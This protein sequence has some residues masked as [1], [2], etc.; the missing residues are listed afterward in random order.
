VSPGAASE[1]TEALRAWIGTA[2]ADAEFMAALEGLDLRLALRSSDDEVLVLLAPNGG[3]AEAGDRRDISITAPEYGW[4]EIL[5]VSPGPGW[6]AFTALAKA[7]PEAEVA[8]DPAAIARALHALERLFELARPDI[9]E[10][11]P[12]G[13]RNYAAIIGRYADVVGP[14]QRP[15]RI[16]YETAGEGMPL[17]MLHTAGA[18]SRQW[19]AQLADTGLQEKW[20]M[21]AFDLPWHGRSFPPADWDWSAYRL[22]AEDYASW[23][24][25][26]FHDVIG[27][28]PVVLGCSMAAAIAVR[29]AALHADEIRAVIAVEAPA[30]GPARLVPE[31]RHPEIDSSAHNP[32]YVRGLMSPNSA[33]SDRR[34]ACWIYSQGGLGVYAGDLWFYSRD[35]DGLALAPK[36]DTERTP[37]T[38]LTG[39]Y[40]YSAS[41]A[42]TRRLAEAIP[43][44]RFEEMPDLG[45][46]PMIEAPERFRRYLVPALDVMRESLW[47]DLNSS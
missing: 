3:L 15:A 8:G 42:D 2:F 12:A 30:Q 25:G 4:R 17:V 10:P 41:P 38:F 45:H 28:R 13:P 29:L 23:C 19:H 7:N 34:Q 9:R 33:L 1:L 40:D 22:T 32:S 5:S 37:V 20:R 18:D 26:F 21:F 36:V 46:F 6:H 16:Y 43:G 14:L 35:Y 31:L 27:V 39:S 47:S 11:G 24:I 44:S